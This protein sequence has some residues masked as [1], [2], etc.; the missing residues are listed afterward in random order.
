[1]AKIEFNVK[2]IETLTGL[3]FGE[4]IPILPKLGIS[5]EDYNEDQV[6][7]EVN[8]NRIDWL[9]VE[10]IAKSIKFF[11][12][13][14]KPKEEKIL[15]SDYEVIID[16]SVKEVR[17]YTVCA[18]AE[19]KFDEELIKSIIQ[20]QEKLHLTFGRNRKKLAIGIY[21]AEKIKF[22]ITFF[23]EDPKKVKFIPLNETREMNGLEILENHEK[24]KEFKH[25]LEGKKVF[26]FFRDAN[27]SILSMPPIINSELTGRVTEETEKVFIECSGFNLF[28]LNK[29]LNV[30]VNTLL[31]RGAKVYKVKVKD[32][33]SIYE[34][35][36]FNWKEYSLDK[37]MVFDYLGVDVDFKLL[38]KMGYIVKDDKILVPSYRADI[39]HNVDLIEDLAIA[40]DYD[41][42]KIQQSNIESIAEESKYS[43]L[44]NKLRE[45]LIGL[46]FFEMVNFN[47]TKIENTINPIHLYNSVNQDYNVLRDVLFL[48]M[49]ENVK[50]NKQIVNQRIFEIGRTFENEEK[51]KLCAM[52]TNASVS[53]ARQILEYILDRFNLKYKF[54]EI[55]E[56]IFIPGRQI[57]VLDEKNKEIGIVAEIHPKILKERSIPFNV[58]FFEIYLDCFF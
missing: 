46:D 16:K 22:P 49:L 44:S 32:V 57:R 37:K 6:S 40:F 34:T 12:G 55:D 2:T 38:E 21:P 54:E 30:I 36:D 31:V 48:P 14:E 7:L 45:L 39:M 17:P 41:N 58:V 27:N 11:K 47:V 9:S 51:E 26:P 28:Y 19:I 13:I 18:V 5:L 23:A 29:A 25:L 3:T 56:E 1:M 53:E 20:L 15:D 50:Q 24:G 35:P 43:K 33:D 4:I 8:P 52:L 42:F 10:G